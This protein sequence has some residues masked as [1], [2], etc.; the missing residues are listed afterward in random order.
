M[1]SLSSLG[2]ATGFAGGTFVAASE[3]NGTPEGDTPGLGSATGLGGA[4]L[5]ATPRQESDWDGLG[6]TAGLG[7]LPGLGDTPA[8]G[9]LG[10]TPA[11]Q[12]ESKPVRRVVFYH[13]LSD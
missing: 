2:A 4:G 8:E 1:K 12:Q 7:I 3:P 5:G 10:F 6:S 11:S 9:G 13:E